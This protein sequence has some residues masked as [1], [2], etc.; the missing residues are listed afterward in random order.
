MLNYEFGHDLPGVSC[1]CVG[2]V[3]SVDLK[4]FGPGHNLLGL[5]GVYERP[6]HVY[7]S[8]KNIVLGVL[9]SA[10]DAFFREHDRDVGACYAGN[11]GVIIYGPADFVFYEVQRLAL[12]PYLLTGDGNSAQTLRSTLHEAVDMRLT[13]V[14]DDHDMVRAVPC[15]HSHAA[16]VVFESSGGDFGR[17]G[18]LRLGVYAVEI[19][20][21]R[22]GN[23]V[24]ERL[25]GIFV[26]EGS[27]LKIGSGL[28]PG[29]AAPSGLVL[30]QVFKQFH[31]I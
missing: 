16:N 3:G 21:R 9:V 4:H 27:Q 6:Y 22:Q 19:L 12:R 8:V 13:H 25:G 14:A 18:L 11:V 1:G 23:V 17:D 31:Y 7:V 24:F 10:V 20:G 30:V 29:P 5:A 15:S 28:T 2:V 26:L